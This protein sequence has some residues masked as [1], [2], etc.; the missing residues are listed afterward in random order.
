M[1]HVSREEGGRQER[2]VECGA[3]EIRRPI[4]AR[5][6]SI[7]RA[8]IRDLDHHCPY[9]GQCIGRQNMQPVVLATTLNP[10]TL[11]QTTELPS[12][13]LDSGLSNSR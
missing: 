6:C 9:S 1:R 2:L 10:H 7:C 5:H 4:T 12:L 3:C 8:C 13:K 11:G